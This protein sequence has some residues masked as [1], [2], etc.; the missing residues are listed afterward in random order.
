MP[1]VAKSSAGRRFS[2]TCQVRGREG[3]GRKA[4]LKIGRGQT[5]IAP[6]GADGLT[7]EGAEKVPS[8]DLVDIQPYDVPSERGTSPLAAVVGERGAITIPSAV[9]RRYRLQSGSPVILEER[10]DGILIRPAEIRPREDIQSSYLES[11]LEGM[12]PENTHGEI[13]WGPSVGEESW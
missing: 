4:I 5:R 3:E 1:R 12:T 13:D 7:L 9:R 8:E 2:K 6:F 10:D 11:L